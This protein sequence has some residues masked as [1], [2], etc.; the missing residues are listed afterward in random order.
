MLNDPVWVEWQADVKKRLANMPKDVKEI[1]ELALS[2]LWT[3]A[4]LVNPGYMYGSIHKEVFDWLEEYS[5]FSDDDTVTTNKLIMLPRGH[6]KSHM[7]ATWC[8]WIIAR[9]PEITILYVSA[10]SPLAELQLFAVKGILTSVNF[11]RFFPEYVHPQEGKRSKWN[12][13]IVSIDHEKRIREGI[14]DATI[15]TA[16]LTTTTTGWHADV[17]VADDLVVP[18]NAYTEIGRDEVSRKSSQFT[19]IRNPGGF[20]LACGT[21]YHAN[22]IY[23]TWKDSRVSMYDSDGEDL[24]SINV[25]EVKEYPV[26]TDGLFLWPRVVRPSDNKFFGFSRNILARIKSEYSD[27]AQF[28]A[29]YY[30]NPNET[31]SNRINRDR[32]QY[33][34]QRLLKRHGGVWYFNGKRLNVFAAIDFAYSLSK[35]ADY[36]ALICIGIDADSNIYVL[37]IDRFKSDKAIEYFKAIRSMHLKWGF[38]KLNAEVTAAQKV[39]VTSIKDFLKQDGITLKVEESRPSSR[40]GS[41]EERIAALL[42]PKYDDLKVFHYEG[43][44]TTALEEE[45]LQARPKNDDLKDGL[46]SAVAIAVPPKKVWGDDDDRPGR[47]NSITFNNRFGGIS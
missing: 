5:L 42:E 37:D 35:K 29:Q 21:R 36:T 41:K 44:L 34:N 28:F 10:T 9:H 33:Y 14:R 39:I 6:L 18:E 47:R 26:E 23:S 38:K 4:C 24:G 15:S 45:L 30:N 17:I 25:W 8:A 3:F 11:T 2:N 16:G 20:T 1:R 32:F 27:V 22:D 40:E 12:N 46:A 31:G 7:V 43:G 19:S 13:T